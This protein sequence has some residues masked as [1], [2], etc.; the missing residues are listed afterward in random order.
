MRRAASL[1][2][3]LEAEAEAPSS[4][5][6][7]EGPPKRAT[8]KQRIRSLRRLLA[9]EALHPRD[10]PPC[11]TQLEKKSL[12]KKELA[13]ASRYHKIKFF[14]RKKL[15]R[16]IKQAER[17]LAEAS[18]AAAAACGRANDSAESELVAARTRLA[19]LQEDMNYVRWFP[20]SE[21][22]IALFAEGDSKADPA[23][24][25]TLRRWALA[26]AAAGRWLTKDEALQG[27]GDGASV[28]D[29]GS[30]SDASGSGDDEEEGAV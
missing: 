2:R 3:K 28:D 23:K 29:S 21:R 10:T 8:L 17:A 20:R 4:S 19:R 9:S 30:S 26:S 5:A 6:A 13:M 12:A 22:Y 1:K 24:A 11:A 14:E 27:Q 18:T 16:K 15:Q 25:A 7:A